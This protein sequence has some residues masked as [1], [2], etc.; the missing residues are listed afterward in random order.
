MITILYYLL[1]VVLCSA[2]LYSYYW[3]VLRNKQFHQYNRIYLLGITIFSWI[4]PFVK[5]N[6]AQPPVNTAPTA[7]NF[8]TIIAVGNSSIEQ[9]VVI[10][11]AKFNWD[12]L[13]IAICAAITILFLVRFIYSLWKIRKMI[14]QNSVESKMGLHLVM[15]DVKGTPFSFFKFI[16]WNRSIDL[17]SEVG[18][19]IL[20][21]E[22]VHIEQKHSFD[23]L[24]I[25]LQLIVA[26]FNP[27]LWFIRSELYLI[28]EFIADDKSIENKDA[29]ELATL[30]LASAYPQ[31]QHIL[32]NSFFF[33]PI[34]RRIQMFTKSTNTKFSY[35]RR[36]TILPIF[37]V[38]ILLFAFRNGNT[39]QRPI[40][41][42]DK[43][44]TVIIDAGHGGEDAGAPGVNG[45]TEKEIAL[46]I[47][48]KVKAINNNPNIKI[49]LTRESDEQINVMDRTNMAN[50]INANLFVSIHMNSAATSKPSGSLCYVP[51]K[52]NKYIQES[53]VLAKNILAATSNLFSITKLNTTKDRGIWVIENVNMPAV[54]V[55]CGYITNATDVATVKTKTNELAAKM[56]DGIEAY[57]KNQK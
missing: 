1:K 9:D 57:L 47:A 37:T 24:L 28:H 5:I 23:K 49:V 38:L 15:T 56:L 39:S 12:N 16:F 2:I 31:Q 21:H 13:V 20:A 4:I 17:N 30:L 26:W 45:E 6:I 34:K 52:K 22:I 40:V 42:L 19:K 7:F 48:Q 33:S 14:V 25:E 44:Y 29:E 8:A 50:D 3:F 27:V 35:L 41:K 43:Q 55:E 36:L 46:M 53:T 54:L 32:S 51:A 10:S 11:N 18:K